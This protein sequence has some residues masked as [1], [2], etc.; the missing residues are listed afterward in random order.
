[1]DPGNKTERSRLLKAIEVSNRA[2]RPFRRKR[3][4]LVRDYVGSHYGTGGPNKGV[5]MNLMFQTAETYAQSLAANRPRVLVTSKFPKY[6][7]FAHHF[8]MAIGNLMKEIHLEDVLRQSVMDA[9]FSI[10]IVKVYNADSGLTLCTIPR[11]LPGQRP[12]LP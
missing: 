7:W 11:L 3:E 12:S 9:F 6:S 1:M 4:S 10:G 8:Q 5:V 2:L